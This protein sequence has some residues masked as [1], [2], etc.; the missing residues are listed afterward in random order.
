MTTEEITSEMA[1]TYAERALLSAADDECLADGLLTVADYRV[2][3]EQVRSDLLDAFP[4]LDGPTIGDLLGE[5]AGAV[6]PTVYPE[7]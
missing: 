1:Y 3:Y 5:A 4:R 6:W 2:I 7:L